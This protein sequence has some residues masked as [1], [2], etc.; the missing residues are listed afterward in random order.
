MGIFDLGAGDSGE[1]GVSDD[2]MGG[3][4]GFTRMGQPIQGQKYTITQGELVIPVTVVGKLYG[5]FGTSTLLGIIVEG[6]EGGRDTFDW[7]IE[8]ADGAEEIRFEAGWKI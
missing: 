5:G 7:P 3:M 6:P 4:K 8:A 1:S 2:G